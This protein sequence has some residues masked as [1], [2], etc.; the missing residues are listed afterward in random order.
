MSDDYDPVHAE[1]LDAI[2]NDT[3][4][5]GKLAIEGDMGVIRIPLSEIHALRVALQ[6]CPCKATKS[7]EGTEMRQRLETALARLQ[8]RAGVRS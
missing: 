1:K 6:P 7:T 4:A 3:P 2:G 8:S 5:L